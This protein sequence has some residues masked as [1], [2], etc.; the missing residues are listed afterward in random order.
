MAA[1]V[2]DFLDALDLES[3]TLVGNDTG[4]ALCQLVITS[5]PERVGRL[6]LTNC[7]AYDNFPPAFFRYLQWTARVPAALYLLAQS[8]RLKPL[9][10]LPLAFG[11][12][13]K[14]PIDQTILDS[15][16]GPVASS[17][18]V[19]RDGTKLLT[20]ITPKYTQDAA[21]KLADFKRPVLLAWAPEDRFFPFAHAERLHET[22]TDSRLERIEDSA[23]FIPEDQPER[24]A[25]LIASFMRAETSPAT[26]AN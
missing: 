19:R 10:R 2:A 22:F 24:L 23:T 21:A 17:E 13:A 1:L 11:W 26:G 3:A 18:G 15:Y 12:L 4:G 5:R 20:S 25:E 6:V 7:D 8:M 9:R 14:R 16:V